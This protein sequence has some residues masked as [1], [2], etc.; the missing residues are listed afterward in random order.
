MNLN[1]DPTIDQLRNL[2]RM[3]VDALWHHILWVDKSGYVMLTGVP[4]NENPEEAKLR[5]AQLRFEGFRVGNQ[6]VGEDAAND[7]EFMAELFD[8]LL[9]SWNKST[10][11]V[12]L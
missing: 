12:R 5:N 4:R 7:S 9:E 6:Y 11:Y 3:G 10:E 2:I 1:D 8:K